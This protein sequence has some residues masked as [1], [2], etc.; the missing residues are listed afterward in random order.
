MSRHLVLYAAVL[1]LVPVAAC[2]QFGAAP[3]GTA[4]GPTT[5]HPCMIVAGRALAP[6][7]LVAGMSGL[8][9]SPTLTLDGVEMALVGAGAKAGGGRATISKRGGDKVLE[10]SM[11][12]QS[13]R[14]LVLSPASFWLRPEVRELIPRHLR[15]PLPDWPYQDCNFPSNPPYGVNWKRPYLDW[16]PD[17]SWL[18]MMMAPPVV[19]EPEPEPAPAEAPA[20]AAA[21][22]PAPAAPA[23][24]PPGDM[25]GAPAADP[26]APPA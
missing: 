26:A 16:K 13:H 10:L 24:A 20:T 18:A 14:F 15:Q 23:G 4:A 7:A 6:A 22:A 9:N 17:E 19:E 1:A 5:L 21:P 2:A 11:G 12:G 25:M 3:A 8:Q